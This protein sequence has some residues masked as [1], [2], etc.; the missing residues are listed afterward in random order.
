MSEHPATES[1][2]VDL[3]DDRAEERRA[4]RYAASA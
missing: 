2:T 1:A 3:E 4:E